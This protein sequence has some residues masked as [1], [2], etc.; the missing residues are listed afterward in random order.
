MRASSQLGAW[1]QYCQSVNSITR[2]QP[3]QA[4]RQLRHGTDRGRIGCSVNGGATITVGLS[5]LWV[6]RD[7]CDVE[8]RQT[9]AHEP[10]VRVVAHTV[11][12]GHEHS[13]PAFA[14]DL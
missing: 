1:D 2:A 5:D 14:D 13:N 11:G 4:P 6:I 10:Q 12:R 3:L 8:I 9:L 7:S